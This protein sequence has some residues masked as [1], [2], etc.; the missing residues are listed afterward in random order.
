MHKF[1]WIKC[2]S[3]KTFQNS[4]YF[5]GYWSTE[6][7]KNLIHVGMPTTVFIIVI[8]SEILGSIQNILRSWAEATVGSIAIILVLVG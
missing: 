5:I 2:T 4:L 7:L 1:N 6:V 8:I 3:K